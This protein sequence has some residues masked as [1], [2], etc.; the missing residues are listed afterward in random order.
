MKTEV[1]CGAARPV[2]S[3]KAWQVKGANMTKQTAEKHLARA[4]ANLDRVADHLEG[5]GVESL[6]DELDAAADRV[7]DVKQTLAAL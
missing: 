3:W 6:S 7:D 5:L 2:V 4:L 1:N